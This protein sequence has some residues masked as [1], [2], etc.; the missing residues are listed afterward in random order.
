MVSC[1]FLCRTFYAFV[2]L[3][4]AE[5]AT[6]SI[7]S[8]KSSSD[9]SSIEDKRYSLMLI[10]IFVFIDVFVRKSKKSYIH[11]TFNSFSKKCRSCE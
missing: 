5:S 11:K 7:S 10:F 1:I 2:E 6:C 4:L 3:C 9:G 8:F